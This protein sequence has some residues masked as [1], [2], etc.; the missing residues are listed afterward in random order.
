MAEVNFFP[1]S[2]V[3]KF[4]AK[5][6]NLVSTSIEALAQVYSPLGHGHAA[7]EIT[8]ADAAGKLEAANVEAALTEIIGMVEGVETNGEV[9]VTS[10]ANA[11]TGYL[12]TYV[13]SQGGTEKGRINIPKD[14]VVTNGS[15]VKVANGVDKSD[16]SSVSLANGTYL[17]LVIANQAE[18]VYIPASSLVDVYTGGSTAEITITVNPDTNEITATIVEINGSKLTDNSVAKTKLDTAVQASLDLADSAYQKPAAGMPKTDM[19]ESVQT[20]LG[21]A[22]T[23]IQP[24]DLVPM[25]EEELNAICI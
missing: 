5:V 15:C 4:W 24:S 16:N 10:P 12:K 17:K 8:V 13:I 19:A 23:A 7:T 14:L 9:A 6:K 21:K 22:D 1:T 20:S 2:L 11:D 18:P 3:G 25:T